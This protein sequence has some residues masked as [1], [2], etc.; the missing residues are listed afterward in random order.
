[1]SRELLVTLK[2]HL[3]LPEGWTYECHVL[4]QKLEVISWNKEYAFVF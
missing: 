3:T 4:A 1:M 2:N